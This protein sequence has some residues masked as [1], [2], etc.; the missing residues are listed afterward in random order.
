M[1]KKIKKK[2]YITSNIIKSTVLKFQESKNTQSTG[3]NNNF[4][5]SLIIFYTNLKKKCYLNFA[6][7]KNKIIAVDVQNLFMGR[8]LRVFVYS[9]CNHVSNIFQYVGFNVFILKEHLF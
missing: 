3:K 4:L 5:I 2:G 6:Q 1:K 8:S 9:S 7:T